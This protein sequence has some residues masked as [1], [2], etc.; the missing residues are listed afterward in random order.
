MRAANL[1]KPMQTACLEA[2]FGHVLQG[3]LALT[4]HFTPESAKDSLCA[5]FG[6]HQLRCASSEADEKDMRKGW[7]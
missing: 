2:P 6:I 5:C 7:T 1:W 3:F 4:P